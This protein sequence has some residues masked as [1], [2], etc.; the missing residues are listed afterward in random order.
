LLSA[1]LVLIV[2]GGACRGHKRG[3]RPAM[4]ENPPGAPKYDDALVARLGAALQAKGADYVPRTHHLVGPDKKAPKYTNRLILE[5]S[6]YLLQHAHN[7]VD[8]HAWGDEAFAEAKRLGR[9]VFLSVG[10][11]TCHWCHVMEGESF[12]DEEIAAYMNAHYVCIKVDREERPDVDAIYMSAVQALTQSGGWPM[13]VWLT[14]AREPFFGGTYFPPRDGARGSRH[15]FLTVLRELSETYAKD[16]E[17]VGRAAKSLVEAVRRDMEAGGAAGAQPGPGA[18]VETVDYF[19]R[20][21]DRV[22]GGVRRAPKFPSNMPVRLLLRHH[23]RTGDAESL[24]MATLTLQKMAG[25]GMYDQ[26]GG[27]FHRYSVDARWLVPHFEKM[28]YDNALLAVAYAEAAQALDLTG[29]GSLPLANPGPPRS[30]W[31]SHAALAPMFARVAREIC[32]YVLREMTSP[33]GAFYSATDAD[34]E[35]EEG[36]FFVWSEAEIIDALEDRAQAGSARRSE[37]G[38]HGDPQRVPD[39]MTARFLRYYGV[40]SGGNFEGA[41]ILNVPQPD[42]AEHAALAPQ[43]AKLYEVRARR[44]PPLRDEKI[45]AA[46]N[47]LMISGFAVAGRVLGEPRYVAAAARAADFVLTKLRLGSG[48][49][50]RSFKDGRPGPGGFLDDYAFL[51]AGLLDLFEAGGDARFLKGA[52]ALAQETESRFADA[53]H[54]GWFMTAGDHEA[55]LAREKPAYD[56]AEPSGTSVAILSVL[57]LGAFTG[58]DKWR[59]IAERAFGAVGAVL[60][61]RPIAM[62]EAL[63]ALDWATDRPREIAIVRPSGGDGAAPLAEVLR[64]TF[65]PNVVRVEVREDEVAGLAALAPVLEGKTATGGKATAYVCERG[66]CQLPTHDPA[67]LAGQLGAAPRPY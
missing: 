3:A 42:E 10:Y 51:T 41:N 19:K 53:Q 1:A 14:P 50:A 4:I 27:G 66:A 5:T 8:W 40:T 9:P 64:R 37:H 46:W 62:T 63:L 7:P 23:R 16:G 15:G 48:Q 55:L 32:D 44:V 18:I 39:K 47:G 31:Q 30:A 34:S 45:L 29:S 52:L 20:A 43:R 61:S 28:L 26:L 59:V 56:G 67:V 11:S 33:D 25:G 21:F 57:R 38:G 13:N 49:L 54:G 60:A 6:P 2:A 58:D 65:L 36:K 12:E 22:E 24:Q 17:R 35:G